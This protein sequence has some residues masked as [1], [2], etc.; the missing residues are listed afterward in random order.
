MTDAPRTVGDFTHGAPVTVRD[1]ASLEEAIAIFDAHRVH[2][3]PVVD[4]C[5]LLVGVLSQTDLVRARA[6]EHMWARWSGLAVKHLMTAPAVTCGPDCPVSEAIQMME[7]RHI[8]RLIVVDES[9]L[10]P[11]GVFST[12]DVIRALA[13]A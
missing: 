1:D 2:G 9:G 10:R 7:T 3:M 13:G 11:I 6:T 12:S 8:H 5:G 4:G